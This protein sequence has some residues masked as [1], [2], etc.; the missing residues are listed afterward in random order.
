VRGY[1]VSAD[2]EN[3]IQNQHWY[4]A[5]LFRRLAWAQL[6]FLHGALTDCQ[7]VAL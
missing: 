7:Q 4:L 3:T 1:D 5:P 6:I 2:K